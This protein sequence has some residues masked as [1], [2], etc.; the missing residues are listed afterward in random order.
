MRYLPVPEGLPCESEL[1]LPII[2]TLP[3]IDC[4]GEIS[5]SSI[6]A[7]FSGYGMCG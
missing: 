7:L 2:E 5:A 3:H 6:F 4:T 1:R